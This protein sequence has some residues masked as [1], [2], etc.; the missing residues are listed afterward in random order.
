MRGATRA[1]GARGIGRHARDTTV[2]QERDPAVAARFGVG[3]RDRQAER[4]CARHDVE[5]LARRAG[6]KRAPARFQDGGRTAIGIADGGRD[7][8]PEER[9]HPLRARASPRGVA[10]GVAGARGR[11]RHRVASHGTRAP[12]DEGERQ[13]REERDGP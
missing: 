4:A 11:A 12:G 2:L 5:A 7:A 3:A 10:D 6:A 9:Q 1:A 8:G 13:W